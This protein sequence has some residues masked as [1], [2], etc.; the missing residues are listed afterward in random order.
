VTSE[1][2]SDEDAEFFRVYGP[3]EPLTLAEAKDLFDPLG[4]PWWI[5]GGLA[6]EAF[7]GVAREHEDIDISMFRKDLAVLRPAVEGRFHMWSAGD[8]ALR[9]VNDRFPEPA[10]NADQVW[11]R[12]H[13]LAPWRADVVLN[14]DDDG[15]WISR[16]DPDFRAPLEQV[17]WERDGI[18]YLKPEI[19]LS[20]KA[21]LSRPK[22]EH[23][24][25]AI[26][27]R[28]DSD[29]RAFLADY[30]ARREPDHPWRARL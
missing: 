20:F 14:A 13:A 1:A 24:F 30:L 25:A 8:G 7:H 11:L 29:A 22:D 6:A 27:P 18:R 19:V 28:L 12:E 15:R 3:W 17:T 23:D 4:I 21:R 10:S 26:V 5:A 9:P 16:R 2:V